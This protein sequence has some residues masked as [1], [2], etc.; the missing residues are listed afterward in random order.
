MKQVYKALVTSTFL[1]LFFSCS[2]NER[3]PSVIAQSSEYYDGN[4]Q[5]NIAQNDPAIE[6]FIVP[7]E[8]AVMQG[9][10]RATSSSFLETFDLIE[11]STET[12]LQ[13]INGTEGCSAEIYNYQHPRKTLE[14]RISGDSST[15]FSNL[16]IAITAS[17]DSTNN[18]QE[19]MRQLN[20][21]LQAV[22]QLKLDDPPKDTNIRFNLSPA[23]PTVIN[24]NKYRTQILE[25][26]FARLQEIA[27]LSDTPS[28]F[29]AS[30][31]KCTS[32]GD[33]QIVSRTFNN[34]ELDIDFNCQQFNRGNSAQ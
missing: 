24:V 31:T 21:C 9:N 32:N 23:I 2:K 3:V 33:V 30:N 13:S 34:V 26:K 22:P 4:Q 11:N 8:I 7:S 12:L 19:K 10:I 16:D 25:T 5:S 14:K 15:Y 17:F 1:L 28:Q 29:N 18:V 27:N 6:K 20:D